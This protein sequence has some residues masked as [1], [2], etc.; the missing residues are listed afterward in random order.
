MTIECGDSYTEQIYVDPITFI[1]TTMLTRPAGVT[2]SFDISRSAYTVLHNFDVV[3]GGSGNPY[4]SLKQGVDGKL[5][6]TN[7]RANGGYGAVFSF[8][9]VTLTKNEL[10]TFSDY[11]SGAT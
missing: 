9:P 11:S 2:F 3:I 1:P 4:G 10:K 8:N 5:Y 7:S 6:G